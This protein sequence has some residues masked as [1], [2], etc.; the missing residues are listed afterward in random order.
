MYI[1]IGTLVTT[2]KWRWTRY[3]DITILG[4]RLF[5]HIKNGQ[6]LQNIFN[7]TVIPFYFILNHQ[8]I[9][10]TNYIQIIYL[11]IKKKAGIV[12]QLKVVK[13]DSY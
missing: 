8:N 4:M 5:G 7:A 13:Y 11:N 3:L 9:I 6:M 2:S 1:A 12:I 10:S